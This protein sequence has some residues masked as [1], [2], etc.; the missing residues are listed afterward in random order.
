MTTS[1]IL[2]FLIRLL[3]VIGAGSVAATTIQQAALPQT[4]TD[5]ASGIS[6]GNSYT[7]AI[8]LGTSAADVT[9]N[10]VGFDGQVLSATLTDTIRSGNTIGVSVAPTGTLGNTA[11]N[12]GLKADGS[13]RTMLLPFGFHSTAPLNGLMTFTLNNLQAGATYST[14]FY[15]YGWET[16]GTARSVEVSTSAEGNTVSQT[17]EWNQF[18]QYSAFYI[19]VTYTLATGTS[20]TISLK[21]L[22]SNNGPHVAGI[23]NQILASPPVLTGL[24]N[25]FIWKNAAEGTTPNHTVFRKTFT[26]ADVSSGSLKIFADSRYVLWINGQYVE[27]GPCRFDPAGPEYDTINVAPYLSAGPNTLVVIVLSYPVGASPTSAEMKRHAPGLTAEMTVGAG[28]NPAIIRTDSSW[29][30]KNGL[31][32]QPPAIRWP[33]FNDNVDAR[34]DSGDW[35]LPAYD[36]SSWSPAAGIPGTGWGTLRPR[37]TPMQMENDIALA[38]GTFPVSFTGANVAYFTL[39]RMVQGWLE[40]D[41]E[42]A[43]PGSSIKLEVGER[44]STT[45]ISDTYN[46]AFNYIAKAGRRKCFTTDD[47]GFRYIKVTSTGGNLTLHNIRVVERRYPYQDAGAFNSSDSFLNDLWGRA[48]HTIRMCSSDGFMDCTLRERA[49]WMGDAAVVEYPVS[50]V[51]LAGPQVPGQPL[52]SDAGLIKNMIRHTAQ[53]ASQFGDGRLKAHACSDRNDIH[54]YIEDYSCLWV[55]SL[56]QTYENTGDLDLVNEVW[57]QLAAQLQWFLN[58]RSAARGLVEAREFV[59]FD[60]PL[61]YVVCE[62]ATLNAFIYRALLDAALLGDATGRTAEAANYRAA[63]EALRTSFNQYLWDPAVNTYFGG[64]NADGSTRAATCHAAMIALDRGIVPTDRLAGTRAY[65]LA[66]YSSAITMPYTA[67]WVLG[68][69]YALDSRTRDIEALDYI[70]EKWAGVMARTDTGTLTEGFNGGEACHN[71]GASCAY[72]LSS[73]V[74]GVRLDGAADANSLIIEPHPSGLPSAGG[75]VVTEHGVVPVS[76]TLANGKLN[77]SC[78]VPAG[79]TAR[80][81]I[82]QLVDGKSPTLVLNGVPVASP[83]IDGRYSEVTVAAGNHQLTAETVLDWK[84][85]VASNLWDL[86]ASVNWIDSVG[87]PTGFFNNAH[88]RFNEAGAANPTV[89]LSGP[90]APAAIQDTSAVNYTLSGSGSLTGPMTLKKSGAGMLSILTS[91][92]FTGQV[93][94]T[95]GTLVMGNSD[96]L[97]AYGAIRF[98]GGGLAMGGDIE[99]SKVC[100]VNAASHADF[101]TRTFNVIQSGDVRSS[102]GSTGGLRKSGAGTLA[103]RGN[104]TYTGP[105]VINAGTLKLDVRSSGLPPVSGLLYQ[106]DASAAATLAV[107]PG[108]GTV[109]AWSDPSGS[110]LSFVQGT[111]ANRPSLVPNALGGKPVVRFGGAQK[112]LLSST[113]APREVLAVVNVKNPGDG[114]IGGFLGINNADTGLRI[115]SSAGSWAADGAATRINGVTTT[116]YTANTFHIVHRYA[117]GWGTWPATG[118]GQNFSGGGRYFQGDVAEVLVFDRTLDETERSAVLDYLN[119]KWIATGP[120]ASVSCTLPPS[121]DVSLASPTAVL[122]LGEADQAVASLSGV[123]GSRVVVNAALTVGSGNS[124]TN[125]AG[126][127]EGTGDL[128]KSGTGHLTLTGPNIRSGHTTVTAGILSIALDDTFG[129]SSAVTLP[130]PAALRLTHGG[131]DQVGSLVINGVAQP[132][133]IYHFGSGSLQVGNFSPFQIWALA[134]GLDGSPGKENS[135]TDDPDQDGLNNLGEFAF[136]GDPLSGSDKGGTHHFLADSI[137]PGTGDELILTTAV[138]LGTPVFTGTPA[139]S[140]AFEGCLYR[141]EGSGDLAGFGAGVKPID[142]VTTGLPSAGEGYEY[143]SFRLES[144]DD[145]AIKGFLRA[146][147]EMP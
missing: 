51:T 38:T 74:L 108:T 146:I 96:S 98:G 80:L 11:G 142:P 95:G 54:G 26:A 119:S 52:R 6:T 9:I 123:S 33:F 114:N 24:Q 89:S 94:L 23:T 13:M 73:Y 110:S 37:S 122:D 31:S 102:P 53:S 82:P 27:R 56:R 46:Y 101:D 138:R 40:I 143:R 105:T 21:T 36:D 59:I 39:P 66:N 55:Q 62:G 81:R 111:A 117:T 86:N 57:P 61:A 78:T 103:L 130:D 104:L 25:T 17:V 20:A 77:L 68:Q 22:D 109:S 45:S 129:D 76:W 141:I 70:R 28:A 67:F 121:T 8:N 127:M 85:G 10:G 125:F 63:A 116:S 3:A 64:I 34:L 83:L 90:L 41:V 131:V 12:A 19:D 43:T 65:F 139:P 115:N 79:T 84:G 134:K 120:S 1:R 32:Y 137:G 5:A 18:G 112:L 42:S 15:G 47:A 91:N 145:L 75:S 106:L 107:D 136:N 16:G 144:S 60:N 124:D 118:F 44:G 88:V 126:N 100:E 7:H 29:R 97:G 49:E 92:S 50:R 87:S 113:T 133:G 147:A 99:V 71:F 69:L 30:W 35:T 140:A 132:A 72:F 4:G 135:P 14:R 48:V 128:V 2:S 93:S 58:R